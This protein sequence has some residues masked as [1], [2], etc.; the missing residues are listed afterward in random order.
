MTKKYSFAILLLFQLFFFGCKKDEI[1]PVISD[2]S[3]KQN[4]LGK[5][6]FQNKS[7]NAESFEWD[8]GTGDISNLRNPTYQF[9]ENKEFS[10][11]LHARGKAGQ[12]SKT[13]TVK[14]VTVQPK[15]TLMFWTNI[16]D[17]G[18]ITVYMD[19]IKEGVIT[20]SSQA[21]SISCGTT[22][23]VTVIKQA[24]DYRYRAYAQSG[25]VWSNTITIDPYICTTLRLI[26]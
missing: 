25:M 15:G 10:V 5:V 20:R 23:F 6:T 24:G 19:D 4:D 17:S 14:I 21:S 8:F 26:K 13:T 2:F 1:P 3:Y 9:D 22:G 18:T 12:N 11:T 16:T 7:L